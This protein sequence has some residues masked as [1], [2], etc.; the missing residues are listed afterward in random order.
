MYSTPS[1]DICLVSGLPTNVTLYPALDNSAL[2]SISTVSV[3]PTAVP[4]IDF[5]SQN[6]R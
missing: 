6:L 3:P 2:I 4:M 1:E 5:S